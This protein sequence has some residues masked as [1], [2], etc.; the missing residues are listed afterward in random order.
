M[1]RSTGQL[2]RPYARK[3]PSE[4]QAQDFYEKVRSR[5]YPW[6]REWNRQVDRMLDARLEA[7][8]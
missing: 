1:T 8:V 5:L 7:A 6:Y 4:A 3:T 2:L